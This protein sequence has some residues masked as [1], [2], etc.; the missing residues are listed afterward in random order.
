MPSIMAH[1]YYLLLNHPVAGRSDA[2]VNDPSDDMTDNFACKIY[3]NCLR[4]TTS[5]TH[6]SKSSYSSTST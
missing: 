4:T 2:Q 5:R 3:H 1:T 6:I